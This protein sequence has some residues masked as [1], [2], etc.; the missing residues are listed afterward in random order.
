MTEAK[1]LPSSSTRWKQTK[2]FLRLK[3]PNSE[4]SLVTSLNEKK[5]SSTST[6]VN[7]DTRE[8]HTRG[9]TW[10]QSVAATV[11]SLV[12]TSPAGPPAPEGGATEPCLPPTDVADGV[13][14]TRKA[15][16][17]NALQ[18]SRLKNINPPKCSSSS[19]NGLP[20]ATSKMSSRSPVKDATNEQA[21]RS[22]SVFDRYVNTFAEA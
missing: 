19:K 4:R 16:R 21:G 14:L 5:T 3:L 9:P 15:V 8:H 18:R 2:S 17:Q 20:G 13:G 6:R 11:S 1:Q 10:L 7:S 12:Y 22:P